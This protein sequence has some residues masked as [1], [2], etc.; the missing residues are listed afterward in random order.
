MDKNRAAPCP[1]MKRS[2]LK[3]QA[4][5]PDADDLS[6]PPPFFEQAKYLALAEKFLSTNA[7][8]RNVGQIDS[9]KHI[10]REKTAKKA[11]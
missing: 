2:R 5:V 3:T 1:I 4:K 6:F 10:Q 7:T 11:A 9:S 8:Q